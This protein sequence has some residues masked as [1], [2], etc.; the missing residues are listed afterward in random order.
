MRANRL[1]AGVIAAL[2][3]FGIATS[4]H[5]QS[6]ADL[7][8]YSGPDRTQRLIDG[9]KKEGGVTLYS[10]ATVADQNAIAGAFQA[11]YGIKV[12]QWRG[13]SEDIRHRAMTETAAGRYEVDL[14]ETAGPDME[15]MVREQLLQPVNTPI[16]A[17]LIPQATFKH[18]PMVSRRGSRSSSAPTTP[19]SS[20]PPTRR[21]PTRT[22]SIPNSRASSASKQTTPTGSSPWSARW[23]RRRA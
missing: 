3:A 2:T 22:C 4:A 8:T 6:L 23:A 16:S 20:S 19:P 17:E 7:A 15:A 14:A 12:T 11:K 21:R 18:R 10:S 5:A 1:S 13:S 9:A